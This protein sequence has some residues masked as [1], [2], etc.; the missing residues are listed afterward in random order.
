MTWKELEQELEICRRNLRRWIVQP[1]R[2]TNQY[3]IADKTRITR[4]AILGRKA[5]YTIKEMAVILDCDY[6]CL[7]AWTREVKPPK[8]Y[9]NWSS[10]QKEEIIKAV[11]AR[12]ISG[13]TLTSILEEYDVARGTYGRWRKELG[14]TE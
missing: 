6:S 1:D 11:E 12:R 8:K 14:L 5:G 2:F 4:E 9:K 13:E 7:T 3:S 10:T